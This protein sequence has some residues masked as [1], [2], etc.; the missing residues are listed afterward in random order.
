M[1]ANKLASLLARKTA[2]KNTSGTIDSGA[3]ESTGETV[4]ETAPD[5]TDAHMEFDVLFD[6]LKNERRRESIAYLKEH[7]GHSTISELSE[8]IAAKENDLPLEAINSRQRKRVYIGLYQCHL[9]R[10]ADAGVVT[11]D[12][13][14]GDVALTGL[15]TLLDP[16]LK[17]GAE[18]LDDTTTENRF[19]AH[20]SVRVAYGAVGLG[21]IAGAVG[22]PVFNTLSPAV[23]AALAGTSLLGVAALRSLR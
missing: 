6:L 18:Q 22:V 11:F 12:K 7:D 15:V 19:R 10:M 1:V 5:P 13:N 21:S 9:P 23:W 14:R 16:Y 3:E 17:L 8:H 4:V 2:G 20:V